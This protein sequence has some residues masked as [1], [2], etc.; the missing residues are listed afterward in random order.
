MDAVARRDVAAGL[1]DA[2]DRAA[3]LQL[4]AGDPV[5]P[6]SLDVDRRLGRL[7]EI[8][9]PGLAAQP[10]AGA[11]RALLWSLG[12]H[13]RR[14]ALLS[15]RRPTSAAGAES[16]AAERPE[17]TIS[18]TPLASS[19][20]R[21]SFTRSPIQA[22]P[23]SPLTAAR[24]DPARDFTVTFL[25]TIMGSISG[26]LAGAPLRPPRSLSRHGPA[27]AVPGRPSVVGTGPPPS[28][29][30]TPEPCGSRSRLGPDVLHNDDG[31]SARALR[32]RVPDR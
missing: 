27:G 29:A 1:G 32:E 5:V 16:A 20:R 8:V 11:G 18:R 23:Y 14:H 26:P 3:G 4:L 6:E 9:E 31:L 19:P 15:V 28:A 2:D 12:S 30:I 25:P 10:G 17:A 22:W 21:V 7:G 24:R 13:A